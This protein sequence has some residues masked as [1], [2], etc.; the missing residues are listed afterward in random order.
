MIK[1]RYL[2]QLFVIQN[3]KEKSKIVRF[4]WSLSRLACNGAAFDRLTEDVLRTQTGEHAQ[5]RTVR[6]DLENRDLIHHNSMPQK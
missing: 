4:A 1:V 5:D 6:Q 2:L 3:L